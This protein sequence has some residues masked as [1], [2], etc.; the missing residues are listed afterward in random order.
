MFKDAG[1]AKLPAVI[2]YIL[3]S[4]GEE[5]TGP[6]FLVF[7]HHRD[8]LDGICLALDKHKM[9]HIRI[10]GKT[11]GNTRQPL[12]DVFQTDPTVR[13]AVLSITAAGVGL[14]LTAAEHV[15]FAELFYNPGAVMQAEDRA[16]RI[17]QKN[18]VQVHYLVARGTIDD[19]L[20][21]MINRKIL[22]LGEA[23]DGISGQNLELTGPDQ[24]KEK[25]IDGMQRISEDSFISEVLK[26][27]GGIFFIFFSLNFL[28]SKRLF[29][30]RRRRRR[31]GGGRL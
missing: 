27:I 15:L 19:A 25:F 11:P 16:H 21:K 12:V 24:N 1:R 28:Y 30:R 5:E 17:G 7:A 8:V 18:C 26:M 22:V 9:K 6:K 14:T 20:F 2:E 29:C 10:D 23:L 4:V 31:R 13:L 3:D